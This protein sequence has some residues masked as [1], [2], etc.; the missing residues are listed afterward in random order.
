MRVLFFLLPLPLFAEEIKA[1]VGANYI[2]AGIIAAV[3]SITTVKVTLSF[4]NKRIGDMEAKHKELATSY[5]DHV[6]DHNIEIITSVSELK[7]M[8]HN[9]EVAFTAIITD[10]EKS[11]NNS[12]SGFE[13]KLI[14][15]GVIKD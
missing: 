9:R 5:Y 10:I 12:L 8:F 3:I 1:S 2:I 7:D 15:A 6:K 13:K 14:L 11:V 4:L